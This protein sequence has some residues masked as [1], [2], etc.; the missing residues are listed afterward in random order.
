MT[1][2]I[3]FLTLVGNIGPDAW[4][5]EFPLSKLGEAPDLNNMN[6]DQL[7]EKL[8]DVASEV[9]KRLRA[10]SSTFESNELLQYIAMDNCIL[11]VVDG[12]LQRIQ[13]VDTEASKGIAGVTPMVCSWFQERSP[14]DDA[15]IKL[16][17]LLKDGGDLV[18]ILELFWNAAGQTPSFWATWPRRAYTT[19]VHQVCA[20][21][22]APED[23]VGNLALL[24]LFGRA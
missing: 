15:Q 21:H 20:L 23:V 6:M 19:V 3:T 17:A 10:C 14:L 7:L 22:Y 9:S 8:S 1:S 24:H 13:A 4:A 18:F 11:M 2:L 5:R 16:A 12:F